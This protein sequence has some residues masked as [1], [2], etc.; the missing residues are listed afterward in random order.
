[1]DERENIELVEKARQGDRKSLDQLAEAARP[2]LREYVNRLTL[3]EDVTQDIIQETILEMYKVFDKLKKAERFR[4]WLEGIA[5]NKV[6]NHYGRKW[7]RREVSLSG[8]G[9]KVARKNSS[10]GLTDMVTA[11]LKEIVVKSMGNLQPRYRAVLTLRCYKGMKYSQ[12]AEMMDCSEIGAQALFYRAKK[13]LAK[14][15]SR[16]GLGKDS[17]PGA[18]VIF[19]KLTAGSEASAA[20]ISVTSASTKVGLAATFIGA[21]GTKTALV[22]LSTAGLLAVGTAVMT[23][24]PGKTWLKPDAKAPG[25]AAA[26]NN[27]WADEPSG[28]Y[29]Y[30]FPEGPGKAV[31]MQHTQHGDKQWLQKEHANYH[32]RNG[33]IYIDNWRKWYRNLRVWRLPTDSPQLTEFLSNIEGTSGRMEHVEI[34]NN[35]LLVVAQRKD[36]KNAGGSW[37]TR[38]HTVLQEDYFQCDWPRGTNIVDN[39][40]RMH[41]RGWT[42]FTITGHINGRRVTGHGRVPF[43][44][45]ASKRYW[46][47]MRLHIGDAVVVDE[48]FTGF[49]RPW[50]GLHTIDIIRRDAA[51]Q[52]IPFETR[53]AHNQGKVEVILTP[54]GTQITYI[55]DMNKDVVEE[56]VFAGNRQGQLIFKYLQD[57]NNAGSKFAEP[58]SKDRLKEKFSILE[59]G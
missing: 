35:N 10:S 51:R 52:K 20:G 14:E 23:A 5:F 25:T 43:V 47:W 55:I 22:T 45:E 19:G 49:C 4:A 24:G 37:V 11:E 34:K 3:Q 16:F 7:H 59:S 21:L 42:Y 18:L 27:C 29:W 33:T 54:E 58:S 36:N 17:L 28:R 9:Y 2:H 53:Y 31:M 40:D 44:Y 12:I 57:I 50:M 1:M 38:S 13:A 6:R 8:L 56:I 15:L 26:G 46:P 30:Y 32:Y 39:R 41:K 48:S